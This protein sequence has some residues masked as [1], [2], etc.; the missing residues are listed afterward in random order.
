MAHPRH[1]GVIDIGKTNAKVAVVDLAEAREIGVLTRPNTFLT[2]PPY[3]HFDLEGHWQFI[4]DALGDLHRAHGIDALSVTTHGASAVLLDA[5]G[6]LAAPMLDYEH[7]G[8]DD[9]AAEYDAIRPDFAETG[10]PRLGMGLN[11]G[12]QLH[13]QLQSDPGLLD[14]VASVLTYP[15]YWAFKLTGVAANEVTSLG[16]HTDLWCPSANRFSSLVEK[17]GLTDKMAPVRKAGE[18]LGTILP[19]IAERTGLPRETKVS[20]GIHD[21]NASLYPHLIRRDPPFSV[22]STGTWVIALAIG[23]KSV[24]LNPARDTLINVN[25]FGDPVPSAR[26]MGGREFDMVLAGRAKDFTEDDIGVVLDRE[27]MLFPA[28]DPRSGPFQGRKHRWSID[29]ASLSDS[30]RFV[31][32]SFY[33]ALVTAECLEMTGAEGPVVVEGPFAQNR[34]YLQMLKAATGRPVDAS[35]GSLTG[36]S[37]GAALLMA[38]AGQRQVRQS[39]AQDDGWNLDPRLLRYAETWRARLG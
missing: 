34:L 36:T 39:C 13:W 16:C 8:P 11:L 3:P 35:A 6:N 12:A 31:A 18:C 27:I 2:G 19:D 4:C 32:L 37:I 22:V 1:V 38:E 29:D 14:R 20:C 23:S 24:Q 25:A 30:E 10:S 21:S 5:D 28:V 9:L 17:L 26:F 15:Q 33:L 7:T